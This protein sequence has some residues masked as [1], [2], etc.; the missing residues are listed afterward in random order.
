MKWEWTGDEYSGGNTNKV[1]VTGKAIDTELVS[2][3]AGTFDAIKLESVVESSTNTKNIVTEWYV[4]G[5][6]LI[7]AHIVIEGGGLEG[8]LR[9]FLGYGTIDFELKEIRNQ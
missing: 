4:K 7:K 6:G 1:K 3:K 2:T 5:T 9:D 8:A